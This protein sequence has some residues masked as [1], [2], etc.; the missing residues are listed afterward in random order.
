MKLSECPARATA[1]GIDGRWEPMMVHALQA[2]P[3]RFGQLLRALP[4]SSSKVATEQLREL[5]GEGI[6]SCLEPPVGAL[7]TS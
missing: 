6:I 7:R 4:E 5:E 3:L 2:K 1:D